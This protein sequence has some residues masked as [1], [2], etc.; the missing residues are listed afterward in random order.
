[1]FKLDEI[2]ETVSPGWG[3]P[4]I[5]LGAGLIKRALV[6]L[7][8]NDPITFFEVTNWL[9]FDA[10]TW[11]DLVMNYDLPGVDVLDLALKGRGKK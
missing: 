5:R 10:S 11:L 9:I 7:D 3:D 2:R 1:M 8:S 4:Y 6:D